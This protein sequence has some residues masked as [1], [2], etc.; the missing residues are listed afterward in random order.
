M[1]M[2]KLEKLRQEV[3]RL[4]EEYNR[5]N[6]GNIFDKTKQDH[7]Y[8]KLKKKKKELKELEESVE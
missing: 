6:F 8:K 2:E 5:T 3:E 1:T 4:E 7:L